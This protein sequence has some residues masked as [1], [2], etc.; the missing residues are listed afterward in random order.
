MAQNLLN[1]YI[2]MVDTIRRHGRLSLRD[3]DMLWRRSSF[4]DGE[5]LVRR[6]FYNYRQSIEDIFGIKI[7][8]DP[9]TYE[10]YVVENDDHNQRLTDWMLNSSAVSEM[11][12]NSREISSR[13]FLEN[14]PSSRE[15]LATII[16]AIKGSR[17]IS[18]DYNNFTRSRPAVGLRF[19]PFVLKVFRQRWYVVGMNVKESRLK[20]YALDRMSN[21]AIENATF[22]LPDGFDPEG[23][24][25]DS[26]G[27]VVTRQTPRR[28]VLRCDHLQAKYLRALPLHQSQQ[29]TIHDNFSLF[30]YRM[31]VT[32]D[33]VDELM[34]FGP[35]ITVVSP[36]ELRAMMVDRFSRALDNYSNAPEV[37]A[38]SVAGPSAV[39]DAHLLHGKT[40]TKVI[41]TSDNK[42]K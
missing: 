24:F 9:A 26:F 36:P 1:K 12:N 19:E 31:R 28:I 34:S 7:E 29:E 23:Y 18:F 15:H 14:I 13:I 4:S 5:S 21:V 40:E 39:T 32:D 33:L 35:R 16:D 41:E 2:W 27:I 38:P 37:P 3:I 25:R 42:K 30:S 6:T 11:L 17:I 10:Y 22:A 8:C 20:T